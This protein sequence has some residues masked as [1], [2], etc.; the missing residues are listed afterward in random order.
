[1]FRS[2]PAFAFLAVVLAAALAGCAGGAEERSLYVLLTDNQLLRLSEDGAILSRRRLGAPPTSFPTYGSLLAASP[3]GETVYA[4]LRAP[5]PSIAA[6]EGDAVSRLRLPPGTMWRRLAVGPETG[7]IYVAGNVAGTR[8]NDLG[9][10][11]LGVRLL[12]LAPD[13]EELALETIREPAGRDWY[14]QGLTISPDET[15]ALVAYHGGDTTGSDLVRLDPVRRCVDSTPAWAACLAEN[16]GRSQWVGEEILAATGER[17]LALLEP[18]GRV[19]RRLDSGLAGAHLMAFAISGSTV[20]AHAD[21]G[22][23]TGISRLSLDGGAPTILQACGDVMAVVADSTLVLGRRWRGDPYGRSLSAALL[24]VD[25]TAKRVVRRVDLP[26]DP[27]D[28]LA[29]R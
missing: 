1:L 12:V 14:V 20:Y 16:H 3:D 13:G 15:S 4:L 28:V 9:D 25:F 18:S 24:Y 17:R 6:I 10:V 7:R 5:R 8:S 11:E 26:D 2:A 27:A 23:G 22:K 29:V 21:C 19:L